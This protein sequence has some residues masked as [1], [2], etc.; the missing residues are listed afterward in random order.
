MAI[1][2]VQ[3]TLGA[4][5][6]W[7]GEHAWLVV[8][9]LA[10]GTLL[11]SR[12][13]RRL[14]SRKSQLATTIKPSTRRSSSISRYRV[15]ASTFCVGSKAL[16]TPKRCAVPGINC[17]NPRA[18]LAETADEFQFDSCLITARTRAGSMRW[19]SAAS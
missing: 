18:P 12:S 3:V 7:L 9:H 8:V 4:L 10:V 17:I 19:R 1:L 14:I 11:F 16:L 15:P 2:V 13:A 6:V 5:N